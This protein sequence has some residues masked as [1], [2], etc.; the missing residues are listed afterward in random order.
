MH[1]VLFSATLHIYKYGHMHNV[2]ANHGINNINEENIMFQGR[3]IFVS[4]FYFLYFLILTFIGLQETPR[5]CR[6]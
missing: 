1:E 2:F 6:M 5:L 4:N 3:I